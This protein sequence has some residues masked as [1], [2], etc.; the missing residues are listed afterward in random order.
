MSGGSYDYA[1]SKIDELRGW[2]G[3]LDAMA[4]DCRGWAADPDLKQFVDGTWAPLAL[5]DRA[6]ILV[7][8]LLLERAAERLRAAI[9]EVSAL[10]DV[11]HD[12]EWIV[13]GD[14]TVDR[15]TGKLPT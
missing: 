5:E 3:T 12:V 1:Y 6:A 10:R 13:S 4:K 14:Y 9:A 11:I 15:L 8:G 2:W 7:R